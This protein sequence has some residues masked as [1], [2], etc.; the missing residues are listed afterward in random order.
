MAK[1]VLWA[2]LGNTSFK[3]HEVTISPRSSPRLYKLDTTLY[4][5]V[6]KTRNVP[7]V[8]SGRY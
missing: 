8:V 4:Q 6:E 2:A 5:G 7:K 3:I 1:S